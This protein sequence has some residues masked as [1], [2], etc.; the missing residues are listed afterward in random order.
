MNHDLVTQIVA[1]LG[2]FLVNNA[3]SLAGQLVAAAPVVGVV[4]SGFVEKAWAKIAISVI[5]NLLTSFGKKPGA[6]ATAPADD[7]QN[8]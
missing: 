7:K 3:D 1:G 4:A 2:Q 8:G 6:P 5:G